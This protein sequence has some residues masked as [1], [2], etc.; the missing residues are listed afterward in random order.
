M[1]YGA[2]VCVMIEDWRM[3]Y[4]VRYGG[5]CWKTYDT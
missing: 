2:Q 1:I 4:G 3:I 5:E